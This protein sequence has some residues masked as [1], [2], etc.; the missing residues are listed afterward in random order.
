[1]KSLETGCSV[2]NVTKFREGFMANCKKHVM[3]MND[4]SGLHFLASA[5]NLAGMAML[6]FLRVGRGWEEKWERS[7]V[8][9]VYPYDGEVKARQFMG[10]KV[11]ESVDDNAEKNEDLNVDKKTY[12][13]DKSA[14]EDEMKE[15]S[16]EG[17]LSESPAV[18]DHV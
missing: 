5:R 9:K 3:R 12:V 13:L 1:L 18:F 15:D 6:T 7:I 8:V 4:R 11:F 16:D 14:E 2:D 17:E 10:G